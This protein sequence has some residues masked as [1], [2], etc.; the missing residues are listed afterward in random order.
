MAAARSAL[1]KAPL[2]PGHLGRAGYEA[3]TRRLV[4]WRCSGTDP[5]LIEDHHVGPAPAEL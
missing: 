2:P 1:K 4:L 3:A 5:D